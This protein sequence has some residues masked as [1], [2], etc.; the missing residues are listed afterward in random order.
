[1]DALIG[2]RG[3]HW[4]ATDWT[5]AAVS[6]FAAGA[7]LMVLDLMWSSLF[8]AHGP[9]RTSHMIAPIFTGAGSLKTAGFEFSVGVVTIA[10]VIHYLMGILFGL[11]M[12][13]LMEQFGLDET[14]ERAWIGGAV[15]G[16]VLYVFNF[17][18]LVGAFP[19]LADLRGWDTFAAHMLFGLVTAL[20]YLRLKRTTREP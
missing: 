15:V 20:L 19:W 8:N 1:M 6:G 4:R 13:A 18:I 14:P 11:F 5:A 17:F 7:I 10:L 16:A 3:W 2:L 12:G 9:W